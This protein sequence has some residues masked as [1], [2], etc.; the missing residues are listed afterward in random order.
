MPSIKVLNQL[1]QEVKELTLAEE[2]FGIEP[3]MQV[4][5]DV[6][7]AQRAGMRQGT[8]DTKNRTEVSGGGKKPYRQKGTGRARQGSIRSPQ[9]VGGGV[10]FGPTPRKYVLK[11]NKKVVQLATKSL[12]SDKLA[13]NSLIVVDKFELAEAKTKNFVQVMHAIGANENK[14]IVVITTEEDFNLVLAG[15]N[16]PN[17]YVQTKSHLSVYDLINAE[18]FVMTEA[19]VKEYE[20][21][22]K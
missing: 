2:V 9:W 18:M 13:N 1:G 11:T 15:R 16:V 6:V 19:A 4:V 21:E 3:N 14:K 7:N 5:L 8:A 20:E 10:V 17:F 22:L 12:L